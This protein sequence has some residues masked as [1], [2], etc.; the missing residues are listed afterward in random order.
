[1][2]PPGHIATALVASR[3]ARADAPAAVVGALAPDLIDKPLAWVLH[4][5]PGGRY[6]GHS[7]AAAVVVSS[8]VGSLR[9]RRAGV[10]FAVGYLA[11]LVGDRPGGGHVPWLMPFV[12]Y[13]TPRER[14][15][16][17]RLGWRAW[18]FEVLSLLLIIAWARRAARGAKSRSA[19]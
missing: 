16:D 2:L 13:K 5:I 3:L 10:G 17:L 4:V 11:H 15:P 8:A 6:L 7:L 1:V 14:R 12:P 19:I 9:G 18:A